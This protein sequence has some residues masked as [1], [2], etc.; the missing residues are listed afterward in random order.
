[1]AM[2]KVANVW[3]YL[4]AN[5][6]LHLTMTLVIYQIGEWLYQ[7]SGRSPFLNPVLI[8]VVSLSF[9]LL[10]TNTNYQSYFEGAQFVHFLLGPATVALAIPLYNQFEQVRRS[11]GALTVALVSGSAVAAGSAGFFAWVSGAT[12]DII[13]SLVPKSVTTPIAMGIAEKL[14]GL[15]SLT[16]AV[17]ILSGIIGA[18]L[19]PPI[20]NF[21]GLLDSRAQGLALGVAS[22]GIGAGRALQINETAAA[23]A[24]IAMGLNGLLTAA[25]LPVIWKSI[26]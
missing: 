23:F 8:S 7:R 2:D 20:M 13:S 11:A 22:H 1:M 18:S 16:A 17:V 14:D 9:I 3:V 6:L 25:L 15:P 5:P 4:S 10:L 21:L 19:G 12:P 26:F 24:G